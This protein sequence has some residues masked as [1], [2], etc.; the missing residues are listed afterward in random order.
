[1]DKYIY[2]GRKIRIAEEDVVQFPGA[3]P[4]EKPKTKP[5][6]ANKARR[7]AKNKKA[8]ASSK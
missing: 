3:I 7:P 5:V 8:G 2:N 6:P 4:I 1:M